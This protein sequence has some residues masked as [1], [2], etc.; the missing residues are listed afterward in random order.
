MKNSVEFS[1]IVTPKI[2]SV[3]PKTNLLNSLIYNG[4]HTLCLIDLLSPETNLN[5][6]AF[7][8]LDAILLGSKRDTYMM[9]L[10]TVICIC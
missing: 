3:I 10:L 8:E 6:S 2:L 9:N 7:T 5:D 4:C 1:S